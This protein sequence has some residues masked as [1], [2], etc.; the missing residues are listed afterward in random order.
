MGPSHSTNVYLPTSKKLQALSLETRKSFGQ[1]CSPESILTYMLCCGKDQKCG[2]RGV[3]RSTK[4]L[5]HGLLTFHCLRIHAPSYFFFCKSASYCR[6][7]NVG[8]DRRVARG[9]GMAAIAPPI[10]KIALT[11]LRL[12][13]LL[14][15]K[16]NKCVS[17]NQRSCLKNI[18]LQRRVEPDQSRMV[19]QLPMINKTL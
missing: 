19:Y 3:R 11:I 6:S 13:K 12:I 14:M 16:P 18:L 17:A 5:N 2:S 10:P 7:S 9:G 1:C 8:L 15:C 4:M